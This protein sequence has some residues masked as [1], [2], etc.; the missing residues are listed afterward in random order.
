MFIKKASDFFCADVKILNE[1][2]VDS[3]AEDRTAL[4]SNEGNDHSGN[5][6]DHPGSLGEI[7]LAG[8]S[9]STPVFFHRTFQ[10]MS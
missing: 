9:S 7:D 5:G 3:D 1:V 6:N 2:Q 4:N 10:V 8:N